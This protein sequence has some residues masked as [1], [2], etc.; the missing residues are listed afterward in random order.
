MKNK[1]ILLMAVCAAVCSCKKES[2]NYGKINKPAVSP[3]K[4]YT[5]GFNLSQFTSNVSKQAVNAVGVT[6][7]RDQIK[8]LQYFVDTGAF[9]ENNVV[10]PYKQITQKSTDPNFGMIS[11]KLPAGDYII[12]LVGGQAPANVKYER[13]TAA[14]LYGDPI[15]YY[16]NS[17]IYDTYFKEII[18]TVSGAVN[19]S[20]ILTRA[21]SEIAVKITDPLPQQAATIK[22]SFVDFP[23]GFDLH[24]GIGDPHEHD[25]IDPYPTAHFSFPV[26]SIDKG[27]AGFTVS[28]P[29]W[30]FFYPTISIDCLDVNGKIIG[31]KEISYADIKIN[32]KYTFSGKLFDKNTG[33]N[34]DLDTKWDT[35]INVPFSIGE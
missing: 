6:S 20:V 12:Y 22:L 17:S 30:P 26:K 25:I 31:H 34:V 13:K 16:N 1:V 21:I 10:K 4:L 33:F 8:Y 14:Q 27:K 3:G 32:T 15:F 7:L 5:V 19:Q 9:N 24:W 29:V 35:P 18:L 11:D 2:G 28:T 23:R